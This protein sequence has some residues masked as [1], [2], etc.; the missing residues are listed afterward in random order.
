MAS[1]KEANLIELIEQTREESDHEII[2]FHGGDIKEY[3]LTEKKFRPYFQ[4]LSA[5]EF[6]TI[7]SSEYDVDIDLDS[8]RDAYEQ[9][10][11]ENPK[12]NFE[13]EIENELFIPLKI[14]I[15]SL[16]QSLNISDQQKKYDFLSKSYAYY[17]GL[18]NANE[19]LGDDLVELIDIYRGY[20]GD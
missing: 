19:L 13:Y 17:L 18:F 16:S 7:F 9:Y 15:D 3:F 11:D 5:E 4:G 2:V 14:K 6:N 20:N 1:E 12:L 10:G 8:L